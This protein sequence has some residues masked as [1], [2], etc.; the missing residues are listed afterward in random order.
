MTSKCTLYVD[1]GY[2]LASAA[3]RVA[4]TSLRSSI[5]VE[6]GQLLRAL[7]KQAG[8]LSAK[9]VL[10]TYWYDSARDGVPDA[11]QSRIG[12]LDGVK[13]RLGRFG[14]DGQQKGVDLRIGL[15]LVNHARRKTAD[16][17]YLVSGDD[18]LS[19]AVEEAQAHGVQV[20]VLAVPTRDGK[21]HG[22]SRHLIR[23]ADLVVLADDDA[24]DS[25]VLKVEVPPVEEPMSPHAVGQD[26]EFAA[27]VEV[28]DDIEASALSGVKA[29]VPTPND[30]LTR[31]RKAV[32]TAPRSTIAYTSTS[33]G[34]GYVGHPVGSG[35]EIEVDEAVIFEV[36]RRVLHAFR[37]SATPQQWEQLQWS[38]PSV[39]QEIDRALLLDAS[40]A[41]NVYDVPEHVRIRV[42]QCFWTL[43]EEDV[44]M[45]ALDSD[46]D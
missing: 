1:A 3:T 14:M 18:D 6:F 15:D 45:T 35:E 38:K 26:E 37:A 34:G 20:V 41:L 23:A 17:F 28:A 19:E 42:R 21:P 12:E 25:A 46:E 40:D 16:V 43:V 7:A 10:R 44:G 30:L 22:L 9:P 36:A 29:T 33:G 13:L 24:L 4:G 27:E 5:H 8:D 39:P 2:L 32:P 11:Q 31:P